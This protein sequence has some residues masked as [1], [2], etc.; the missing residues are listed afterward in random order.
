MIIQKH[1]YAQ[2]YSAAEKEHK[3]GESS[4]LL[5]DRVGQVLPV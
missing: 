1:Q 2:T 3:K 4:T 5:M